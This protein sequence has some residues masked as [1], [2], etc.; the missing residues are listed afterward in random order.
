MDEPQAPHY[1]MP[2]SSVIIDEERHPKPKYINRLGGIKEKKIE[3]LI[4][5]QDSSML[6]GVQQKIHSSMCSHLIAKKSL[7]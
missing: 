2:S 4:E 3:S 1:T 7:L 5:V 6:R